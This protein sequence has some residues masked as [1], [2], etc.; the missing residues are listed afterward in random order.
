MAKHSPPSTPFERALLDVMRQRHP[1][2][3][4]RINKS[5]RLRPEGDGRALPK[6]D[7]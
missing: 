7:A 2:R 4:W 5:K 3:R 6:R 1:G